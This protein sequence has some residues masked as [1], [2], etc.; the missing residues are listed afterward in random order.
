MAIPEATIMG[1]QKTKK[2]A[3]AS[4]GVS[5]GLSERTAYI[6]SKPERFAHQAPELALE[7][8]T[9]ASMR[10]A[11]D[12][13]LEFPRVLGEVVELVELAGAAAVHPVDVLVAL[14]AHRA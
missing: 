7:P 6:V 11:R 10:A 4:L 3:A 8:R 5:V 12:A 13:V 9:D 2:P 1:S 14:G